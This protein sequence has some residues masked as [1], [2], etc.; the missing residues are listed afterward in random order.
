MGAGP[1]RDILSRCVSG[2]TARLRHRSSPSALRNRKA[3]AGIF[4]AK[5][6]SGLRLP[7]EALRKRQPAPPFRSARC[8]RKSQPGAPRK[9]AA[10]P[11]RDIFSRCTCGSQPCWRHLFA[12]HLQFG[13]AA[14]RRALYR[15]A[16]GQAFSK[17]CGRPPCGQ[18]RVILS[19]KSLRL[20]RKLVRCT[21]WWERA[22]P[23]E[24]LLLR[25]VHREKMSRAGPAPTE[26]A[27]TKTH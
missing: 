17:C 18:S 3:P 20:A 24:R 1:A 7:A 10:G 12:M 21:S 22:S 11:A 5:S 6:S 2:S 16:S 8:T 19:S 26:V 4:V 13:E 15:M 27:R 25:G 23:Y 9:V 14:G